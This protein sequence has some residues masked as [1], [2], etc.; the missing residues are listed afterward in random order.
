MVG[1]S[2]VTEPQPPQSQK[3][4]YGPDISRTKRAFKLKQ[5]AFFIIFKGLYVFTR[6][7]AEKIP[8]LSAFVACESKSNLTNFSTLLIKKRLFRDIYLAIF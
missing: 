3:C 7:E 6:F 8:S 2:L 1:A 5:K 4:G